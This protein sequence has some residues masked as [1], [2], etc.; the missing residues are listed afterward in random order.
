MA[1]LGVARQ[2]TS[3]LLMRAY[4]THS[5]QSDVFLSYQHN[6]QAIAL[7]LA[8]EL[9]DS[10]WDVFIDVHDDMLFPGD[11]HIDEALVE[12]MGNAAAML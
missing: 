6:D 7:A 10:Q 1:R 8:K 5:Q 4:T 12:A 9:S 3:T 2:L 11:N